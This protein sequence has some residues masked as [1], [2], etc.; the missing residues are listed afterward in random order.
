MDQERWQQRGLRVREEGSIERGLFDV[1][2]SCGRERDL[3]SYLLY[4]QKNRLDIATYLLLLLV[5]CSFRRGVY[6]P[7]VSTSLAELLFREESL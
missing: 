4:H 6:N 5:D 7:V 2:M 3:I 1:T